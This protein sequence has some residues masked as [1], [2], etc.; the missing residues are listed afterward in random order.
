MVQTNEK[1]TDEDFSMY[2]QWRTYPPVP[3]CKI[4]H[5]EGINCNADSSVTAKN[6]SA[7]KD[8]NTTR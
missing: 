5:Q 2:E 3:D 7:S 4:I 8:K 1:Y 6:L